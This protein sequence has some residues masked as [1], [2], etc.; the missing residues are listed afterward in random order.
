V[1]N[2]EVLDRLTPIFREVFDDDSLVIGND[3]TAADVEGWDSFN[4]ISLII[5]IESR[6][7]VR[8]QVAEIEDLRNV[9][10]LARLIAN[11]L[12]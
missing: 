6:L 9:G 4:H 3:T 7:N 8:F 12:G 11:K 2:Q 1:T 5:A 10:E